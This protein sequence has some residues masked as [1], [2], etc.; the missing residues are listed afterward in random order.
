MALFCCFVL[1]VCFFVRFVC[2]VCSFCFDLSV[3]FYF[4]G[5]AAMTIV[6]AQLTRDVLW[7]PIR[8]E[9]SFS[10]DFADWP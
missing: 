10:S 3:L 6:T 2:F 9:N 8:K 4:V 7:A 1:F 5:P